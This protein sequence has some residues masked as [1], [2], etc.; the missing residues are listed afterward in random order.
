MTKTK[1]R[2]HAIV[3]IVSAT[4]LSGCGAPNNEP[5]V[6]SFNEASVGIRLNGNSLEFSG[7]EAKAEAFAKADAK[8]REICAR[9]PNRKA[10]YASTRNIPTGQ[11]TYEIE[12]L[13]LCLK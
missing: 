12:R 2:S 11:Y 4:L 13:Y 8:A 7:P 1:F 3:I 6:V 5:V 9:G 10:E